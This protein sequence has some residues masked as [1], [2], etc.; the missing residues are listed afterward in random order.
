[1]TTYYNWSAS[2][3]C[4][5]I[6]SAFPCLSLADFEVITIKADDQDDPNS[7]NSLV[8]Y[9]IVN[10]EPKLPNANLFAINPVSGAIRVNKI[11]L[12]I[13]VR[14][15]IHLSTAV[16]F[17][18]KVSICTIILLKMDFNLYIFLQKY[19]KY[20][21]EVEAADMRGEG[22]TVRGRVI[23]TVTD[24]NDIAPAFEMAQASTRV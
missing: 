19:P 22:L 10:Q 7:D 1:M 12:D 20:T 14:I 9:K 16:I 4:K 15:C 24:S 21:L 11:G 5:S 13:E 2:C 23:L 18:R 8:Y 3:F 17:S 6:L